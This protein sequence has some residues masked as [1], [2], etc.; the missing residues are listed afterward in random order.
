MAVLTAR[1][2][3]VHTVQ[4]GVRYN[5]AWWRATQRNRVTRRH[6]VPGK[7]AFGFATVRGTRYANHPALFF[8]FF[9]LHPRQESGYDVC[10]L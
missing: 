1:T 7:N 10:Y 3:T 8:E 6:F 2:F 4:T 9:M 5:V